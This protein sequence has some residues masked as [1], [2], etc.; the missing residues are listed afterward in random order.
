MRLLGSEA[1]CGTSSGAASSF[2]DADDVRLVNSGSTNRLVTVTDSSGNTV[3]TFTLIAGEVTFLR[4]KREEKIFAAH[5]E[6][7][8]VGVVTP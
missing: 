5:A 8:G 6:I 7:L 4:K 3:A 2:G 1:A